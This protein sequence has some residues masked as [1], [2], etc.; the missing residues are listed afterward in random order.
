MSSRTTATPHVASK[1]VPTRRR[2][3]LSLRGTVLLVVVVMILFAGIAP[4]R[5]LMNQRAQL[6]SLKRQTAQ[7]QAKDDALQGRVNQL[8]DPTYIEQ[9]ARQC[10]GMVMPGQIAFVTIP[11]RGAPVPPPDC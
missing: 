2:L 7:L 8:N 9:L 11:Q 5:N 3:R 6:A 4:F 1:T 10:L